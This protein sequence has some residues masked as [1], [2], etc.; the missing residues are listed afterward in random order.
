MTIST[1]P[2]PTIRLSRPVFDTDPW[3]DDVNNNF[4]KID[5]AMASLNAA[6][7][8]DTWAANTAYTVGQRIYDS[9]DPLIYECLVNHTS[10]VTFDADRV[11]HPSYWSVITTGLAPRGAWVTTTRYRVNDLVYN[12]GSQYR[13]LVD[14]TA[15]VFAT[16]LA[17]LKWEIF[18]SVGAV[19]PG[20]GDVTGPAGATDSR[21]V[22]FDGATGKL[23]KDGGVLLSALAALASPTFSGTPTVPDAADG[24]NTGQAANTKFVQRAIAL[25]QGAVAANLD[26]LVEIAAS[27][28]NDPAFSTTM[29]TALALKAPLASPALTGNPTAPTQT[30][31]DNS[32][33]LATT[34]YVQ[35]SP[36]AMMVAV[37]DE[38]TAITTG[39]AKLTFRMPYAFTVT[40]VKGSLSTA[41]SSGLPQFDVNKNGSTIF[42]TNPTFDVSEKTTATAATPSVISG[43]TVAFAADDEV[44]IDIDTAGTGAKGLKVYLIGHQ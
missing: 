33:K 5:A 23:I 20:G 30:Q 11:A 1:N 24:T 38:T 21:I 44:T 7:I 43:S 32:T 2:T 34:A 13:C 36:E 9:V 18:A 12:A 16:D 27:I 22:L 31:G 29:N 14:H 41:S 3:H 37:S 15:G 26:T 42:S 8:D 28:N 17:A 19:G 25:I 4:A 40:S 6:T 10:G 39:T 35:S